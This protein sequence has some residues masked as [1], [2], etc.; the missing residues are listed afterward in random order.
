MR[1]K[2]HLKA[3]SD[4]SRVLNE[5]SLANQYCWTGLSDSLMGQRF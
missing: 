5:H 2:E 4:A 1:L 3:K